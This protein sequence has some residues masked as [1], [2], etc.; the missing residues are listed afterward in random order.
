MPAKPNDDLAGFIY[1]LEDTRGVG[2]RTATVYASRVRAVLSM[3]QQPINREN[4]DAFMKSAWAERSRDGYY[5][6]WNRF[7]EYGATK[8][9]KLATP[10][11]RSEARKARKKYDV[12]E[13]ILAHLLELIA[14]GQFNV[15]LVPDVKWKHFR[16][17]PQNGMWQMDDP[18]ARGYF[19]NVPLSLVTSIY[20]WGHPER[21]SPE[22]PLIPIVCGSAEPMPLIPLRRLL[23]RYR[24]SR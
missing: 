4:L 6:A 21:P 9:V 5:A 24:N 11:L 12:P 14:T 3:S 16:K 20:E 13:R 2:R 18:N 19:Y 15:K 1:W 8:N 22:S 23:A 7:V 17:I 10:T